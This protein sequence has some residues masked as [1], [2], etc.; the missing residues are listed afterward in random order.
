MPPNKRLGITCGGTGG[1]VYPAIAVAQELTDIDFFFIGSAHRQD[2]KIVSRYGFEY[3]P[4]PS[5]RRNLWVIYKA[6]R[7]AK[8]ILKDRRVDCLLGTGGYSTLPVILAAFRLGIP[9]VLHE[10]NVLPG[11]VNRWMQYLAR[12]ILVSFEESVSWFNANKTVV[13]G[14]PVRKHFPASS[15]EL[16]ADRPV[17]L[18]FGGSQGAQKLNDLLALHYDK[19]KNYTLVHITGDNSEPVNAGHLITMPY[20]ENMAY[21]YER[22]RLV[23][24][25]AGAT[26]IA[27]LA[28]FGVPG[29]LIPYPFAADNHQ[30]V[31]A[32]VFEKM[33]LGFYLE[34]KHLTI[35]S[36]LAKLDAVLSIK[37]KTPFLDARSGVISELRT[38]LRLR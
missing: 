22:A 23:I 32:Q 33:G 18:V 35:D 37:P 31:N 27:E 36:L 29:L 2:S 21:L 26:S 28:Y 14:N 4:I 20:F 38:V 3:L 1:H 12:R 16:P 6:Y 5:S 17:L 34:E 24:C 25:R 8:K 19:F 7:A 13:T 15:L 9:I 11:K 30:L 10:Q